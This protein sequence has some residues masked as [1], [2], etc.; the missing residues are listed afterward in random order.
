M[1]GKI[2]YIKIRLKFWLMFFKT[3]S[4]LAHSLYIIYIA[5]Y[6]LT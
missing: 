3:V 6:S 4:Y 1:P 5:F 2:S